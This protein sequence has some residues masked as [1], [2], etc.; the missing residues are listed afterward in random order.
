MRESR[1]SGSVEGVMGNYDS[2]SDFS[3]AFSRVGVG[4]RAENESVGRIQAVRRGRGAG[5]VTRRRTGRNEMEIKSVPFRPHS[6][7]A[8]EVME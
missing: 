5:R 3:R 2:Y 7:E 1:S 8:P 6:G 4:V